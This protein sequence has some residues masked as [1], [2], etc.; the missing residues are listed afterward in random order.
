MKL[1]AAPGF[2]D[3]LV[4]RLGFSLGFLH[5]LQDHRGLR[6]SIEA[7]IWQQTRLL[8]SVSRVCDLQNCRKS[9]KKY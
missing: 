2:G 7:T 4:K 6:S 1:G 9:C 3:V 5:E 8:V